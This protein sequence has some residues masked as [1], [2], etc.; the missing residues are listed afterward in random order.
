MS[1][2]YLNLSAVFLGLM[3]LWSPVAKAES[4]PGTVD[5]AALAP[6]KVVQ[7]PVR[8]IH[9]MMTLAW[10]GRDLSVYNQQAWA[11]FRARFPGL[12]IMHLVSPAYFTKPAAEQAAVRSTLRQAMQPKDQIGLL[13]GNWQSLANASGV[14]FR[15]SPTFWGAEVRADDCRSD[16]GLEVPL[17]IYPAD[18]LDKMLQTSVHM[19]E[20]QGFGRPSALAVEGWVAS[21]DILEAAYRAGMRYDL[22]AVSPEMIGAKARYYPIYQWAKSLWPRITPHSQ[23]YQIQL[24]KGAMTELPQSLAAV[25]YLAQSDI[26]DI[27]KEY[28]ERVQRDPQTPLVFPLQVYQ[29]TAYMTLPALATTLQAVFAYAQKAGVALTPLQLPDLELPEDRLL[30]G[31]TPIAH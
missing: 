13:L 23:P 25:D 1:V 9:L 28:V 17:N 15:S 29:E 31:A 10:E 30:S 5:P 2:I 26:L 18:E 24:S 27:F 16:C 12:Q 11:A 7:A 19:L 22:S 4:P 21:S 8:T 3:L 6:A 14:I 20:A